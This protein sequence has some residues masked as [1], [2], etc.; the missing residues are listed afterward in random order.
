NV[1]QD[2][3]KQATIKQ[4]V[5]DPAVSPGIAL[6]A[7]ANLNKQ[8]FETLMTFDKSKHTKS[9][10]FNYYPNKISS[11]LPETENETL[12]PIKHFTSDN[13]SFDISQ[14]EKCDTIIP[15]HDLTLSTVFP[16]LHDEKS[17]NYS[18]FE[19]ITDKHPNLPEF[20]HF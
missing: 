7:P 4:I 20:I 13:K 2:N 19:Y 15:N 1:L 12:T 11:P 9:T 18:S 17:I 8:N 16:F 3:N 14:S 10:F 6:S 5:H